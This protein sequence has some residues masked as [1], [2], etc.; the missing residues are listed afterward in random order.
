MQ[1][2]SQQLCYVGWLTGKR[3]FRLLIGATK[4]PIKKNR[5]IGMVRQAPIAGQ[6]S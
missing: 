6:I 5:Q 2:W 3:Y 4:R 1:S